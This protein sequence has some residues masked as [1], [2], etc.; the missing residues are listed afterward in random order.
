MSESLWESFVYFTHF[1]QAGGVFTETVVLHFGVVDIYM[2]V[3]ISPSRP[4]LSVGFTELVRLCLVLQLMSPL[5]SK[6][7]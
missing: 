1:S 5:V 7:D 3:Y 6:Q 2:Y 4:H